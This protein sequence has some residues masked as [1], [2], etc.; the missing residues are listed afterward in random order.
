M[1]TQ[2]F[3][4]LYVLA[5]PLCMAIDFLWLGF[6]A[7]DFYARH[8]GSLLGE[9]RWGAAFIFYAIFLVGL[10]LFATYPAATRGTVP[11]AV[12]LGGLFGFFSYATYDLTNLATLR[13]WSLTISLVD[14]AW[15]SVL[16][17]SVAGVTVFLYS[18]I[19]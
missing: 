12:V 15:G 5:F 6:I 18:F 19:R 13:G 1:Q 9:V 3:I 10:T 2:L 7:K 8:I 16:G 11:S 4:T 14:I 17:A